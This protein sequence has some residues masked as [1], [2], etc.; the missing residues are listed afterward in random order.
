MFP[1]GSIWQLSRVNDGP[2]SSGWPQT[3]SI[4]VL[5]DRPG[6]GIDE[7][8]P[9]GPSS[10]LVLIKDWLVFAWILAWKHATDTEIKGLI[11]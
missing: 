10:L 6:A 9:P 1:L 8:D 5:V 7:L 2:L 4:P 11:D 3:N